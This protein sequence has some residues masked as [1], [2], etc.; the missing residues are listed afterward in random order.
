MTTFTTQDRES[1]E[2]PS[3]LEFAHMIRNTAKFHPGMEVLNECAD[4]IERQVTYINM[5]H[6]LC[7]K[8]GIGIGKNLLT[9]EIIPFEEF[10]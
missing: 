5:L 9:G 1:A 4:I 3:S 2:H 10:K 6:K 7:N 8:N